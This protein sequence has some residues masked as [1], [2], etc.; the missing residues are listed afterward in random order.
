LKQLKKAVLEKKKNPR[1]LEI[2]IDDGNGAF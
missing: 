1:E 2:E